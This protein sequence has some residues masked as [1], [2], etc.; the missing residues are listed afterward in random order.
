MEKISQWFKANKLSLNEAK[1]KFT[2]FHKPRDEDDL[3]LQLPN[4]K[5]NNSE[6]RRSPSIKFLGVLFDENLTRINHIT[7]VENK[8]S[9]SLRLLHK[10]KNYLSKTSMGSLYYSFINSYLNYGNIAWSSTSMTKIKNF[11][12]SKKS[13]SNYSDLYLTI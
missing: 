11:Y 4:L 2:L 10:A 7:L 6:I 3:P 5:T 9:K 8:L 13:Y 12:L 1:T